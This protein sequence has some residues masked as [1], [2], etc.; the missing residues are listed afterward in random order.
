MIGR[1][2]TPSWLAAA[3]LV[4]FGLAVGVATV[5]VA[6][7][8]LAAADGPAV[9][10]ADDPA[11]VAGDTTVQLQPATATV[12]EGA[13][14]TLSVVVPRTD[15]GVGA[16]SG[17]ITVVQSE[18]AEIVDFAFAGDPGVQNVTSDGD[19]VRFEAAI[20]D[21]AQTGRVTIAE[22]TVRG[23]R[24][25]TT[26]LALSVD[27]LGDEAGDPYDVGGT[28]DTALTVNSTR[29]AVPLSITAFT[30]RVA[31]G[32]S[33]AFAVRR[34][35]SGA[36]VEANVT[37][38]NRTV[39]TGVDGRATVTVRES[40][41]A[42]DGT[43]TAVAS[44]DATGEERFL[45]DTVTLP[46][47]ARGGAGGTDDGGP[48]GNVSGVLVRTDPASTGVAPGGTTTVD[49]VVANA[50][51]GVGAGNLT[52]R[53]ADPAV[54]ELTNASLLGDPGIGEATV[55][56]D[57]GVARAT[58]ALRSDN[59]STPARVLRLTLRGNTTGS[60]ALSLAAPSLG[61]RQGNSYSVAATAAGDVTVAADAGA[62]GTPTSRTA[63]TA[64]GDAGTGEGGATEAEASERT[65][66]G[67]T[68]TAEGPGLGPVGAL[69]ALVAFG[70][71]LA[72]RRP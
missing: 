66:A 70:G 35:D 39:G 61:D 68:S 5:S 45:D 47:G 49:V 50:D 51:A 26:D 44:K 48:T 28:P 42:A 15:G 67:G 63:T 22:V 52:V 43:V 13:N 60:T 62:T 30:D 23:T 27:A 4:A 55:A 56:E 31:A 57:G 59:G 12:D 3:T 36:R 41:I 33:V 18:H 53:V 11:A 17:R 14:R 32:E 20:M 24:E 58:F 16:V 21:T 10:A 38:G 72:G 6:G 37:V 25:G 46:T 65:P 8:S 29:T 69:L 64:E 71:W 40:M 9:V 2:D 1:D 54:A 19:T 34:A 7:P